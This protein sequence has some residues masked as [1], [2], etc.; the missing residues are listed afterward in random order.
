MTFAAPHGRSHA[1]N[2]TT[3]PTPASSVRRAGLGTLAPMRA[4]PGFDELRTSRLRLRRSEPRDAEQIWGY[5]S[6][7]DVHEHQGWDH[8][9]PGHIRA[10]IEEMLTRA[11]GEA[12]GWV[13]FTVETLDEGTLIGGVGLRGGG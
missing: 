8:T 12:G 11:P 7:P 9:D 1:C 4:D 6:D 5:R 13:P 2:R 3:S 10:E